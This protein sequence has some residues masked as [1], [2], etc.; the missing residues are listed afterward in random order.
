MYIPLVW[1]VIKDKDEYKTSN[2]TKNQSKL[3]LRSNECNILSY[4]PSQPQIS[5]T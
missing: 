2:V 1:Y 4:E 5:T 3:K